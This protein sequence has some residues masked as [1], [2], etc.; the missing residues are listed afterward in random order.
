MEQLADWILT[1]TERNH[2]SIKHL[3]RPYDRKILKKILDLLRSK[4]W[5]VA[6]WN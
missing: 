2:F 5:N 1:F 3:K 4:I 6:I